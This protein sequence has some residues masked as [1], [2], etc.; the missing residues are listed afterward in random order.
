MIKYEHKEGM[1]L[2]IFLDPDM[3]YCD[4]CDM[5]KRDICEEQFYKRYGRFKDDMQKLS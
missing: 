2:C 4:D 5:R 1:S 3:Y